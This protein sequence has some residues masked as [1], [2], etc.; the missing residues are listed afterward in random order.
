MLF[1]KEDRTPSAVTDLKL[2]GWYKKLDDKNRMI[3]ARYVDGADAAS[4]YSFFKSV[5]EKALEDNNPKFTVFVCQE[6]YSIVEMDKYE[7]F[8]LN[9][10]LIDAYIGAQ[11]Y[12]D[13]K[14]AC[15]ANL[16]LYPEIKEQF[17]ADNNGVLPQKI[18][19][20]N[21]YIDIIIGVESAYDLGF[22][23]LRKYNEMGLIT[24]EELEY[25]TNSLK[26]HRLQRVFDGI[27]TYRPVGE[28]H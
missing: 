2:Q 5:A 14:A 4:Q 23:M 25:R 27:Y 19:F 3:L 7:T 8:K 22:E 18:N 20:R 24:D 10:V 11:R 16:A 13:A 15:D 26:T 17:L 21:R 1:K 6:C 9:E 28:D 12:D